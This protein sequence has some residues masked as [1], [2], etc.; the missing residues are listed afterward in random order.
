MGLNR[1]AVKRAR[2]F[3]DGIAGGEKGRPADLVV[4]SFA[5]DQPDVTN[6]AIR[7]YYEEAAGTTKAK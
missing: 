2:R 7:K 5:T 6:E 3:G 1:G 4:M